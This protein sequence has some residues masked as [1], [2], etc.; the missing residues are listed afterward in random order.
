MVNDFIDFNRLD[1]NKSERDES[2]IL[3][4]EMILKPVANKLKEI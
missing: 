1:K 2:D 3:R 4:K